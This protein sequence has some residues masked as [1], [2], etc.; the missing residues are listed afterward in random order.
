MTFLRDFV[1]VSQAGVGHRPAGEWPRERP[2]GRNLS[3]VDVMF[4]QLTV[5]H[6]AD[7]QMGVMI[8]PWR[9]KKEERTNKLHQDFKSQH[10]LADGDIT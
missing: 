6:D 7:R 5:A 1:E 4:V 10:C 3:V 9:K 2:P 8:R